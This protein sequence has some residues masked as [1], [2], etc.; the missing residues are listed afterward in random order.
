MPWESSDRRSR[1]PSDWARR[2]LRVLRRDQYRCQVRD[3]AGLKCLERS[4]EVDHIVN[5]DDHDYANLQTICRVHHAAKTQAE[6]KAGRR[7]KARTRP[8]S[9]HPGAL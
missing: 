3:A 8:P 1:L 6:A 4:N 5:N 2:R 9:R 7:A